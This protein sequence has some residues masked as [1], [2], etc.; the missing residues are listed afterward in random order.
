MT[1][2]QESDNNRPTFQK[3][4]HRTRNCWNDLL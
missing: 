4:C 3:E 2:T 1:E